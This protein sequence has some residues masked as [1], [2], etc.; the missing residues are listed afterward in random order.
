MEEWR[1]HGKDASPE[2]TVERI[3][4]ALKS[5][6][7]ETDYQE[8]DVSAG[9]CYSSRVTLKDPYGDEIGANGKGVSPIYCKA[10]AYAELMERL[11]NSIFFAQI[12]TC[13][14]RAGEFLGANGRP[15]YD[16]DRDPAPEF[17]REMIRKLAADAPGNIF[18]SA[19]EN[20][21]RRLKHLSYGVAPGRFSTRPYYSLKT[22]EFVDLPYEL[23]NMFYLSN[24]M[25]AGNTVEE[26]I[27]QGT[28]EIFE[29]YSELKCLKG[30][31]TPPRI[32]DE[33]LRQYPTVCSIIDNIRQ[34]ERYD[35]IV[36]DCSLG[37]GLSTV[38]G[39]I[40]DK[41]SQTFGI[42]FGTFPDMAIALERVFSEAFQGSSLETTSHN[43]IVSF[44]SLEKERVNNWNL[45]KIGRGTFPATLL[46]DEPSYPFVPWKD[47]SGMSNRELMKDMLQKLQKM[48]SDVYIT[49][50]DYLGL[51]SVQ[52]YAPDFSEGVPMDFL[53]LKEYSLSEEVLDIFTRQPPLTKEEIEKILLLARVKQQ[54]LLENTVSVMTGILNEHPRHCPNLSADFLI[55]VCHYTLGRPAEALQALNRILSA[56]LRLTHEDAMYLRGYQFWLK[57]TLA[58]K[59][60][61][62]IE[63]VLYKLCPE[64]IAKQVI[65]D[66]RDPGQ[67]LYKTFDFCPGMHCDNCQAPCS[68]PKL[69]ALYKLLKNEEAKHPM[70]QAMLRDLLK[71]C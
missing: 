44:N 65:E 24:G 41:Y 7:I 69:F 70:D 4:A 3:L 39:I 38:C 13:D 71:D 27:V 25:A 40:I 36:L 56:Y 60:V 35:V 8:F 61:E 29:R 6:G 21:I 22:R 20:V 5:V 11:Q 53:Q 46:G 45:L 57:G 52:I 30:A 18:S 42:K 59:P 23:I 33:V 31:I 63:S 12:K 37:L 66:F 64:D 55:S 51:P 9:T 34:N 19:E 68:Y 32:P 10:S 14:P 26:A 58:N 43:G 15:V 2:Q 16:I 67:A 62:M 47:V 50:V 28:S 1:K 48:S 17:I 49:V 54:S